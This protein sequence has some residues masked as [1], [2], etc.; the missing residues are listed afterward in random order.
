VNAKTTKKLRRL[1]K[2]ATG[3]TFKDSPSYS[4]IHG[5][6]FVREFAVRDGAG[7][8]VDVGR[9][10]K[11]MVNTINRKHKRAPITMVWRSDE[12]STNAATRMYYKG[13]KKSLDTVRK[14]VVG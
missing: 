14:S 8:M 12:G 13:L 1:A 5:T 4:A 10:L 11:C 9:R 3:R 7:D 2:L 6:M